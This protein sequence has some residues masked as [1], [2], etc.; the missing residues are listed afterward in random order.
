MSFTAF[1]TSANTNHGEF[2]WIPWYH[3]APSTHR[4]KGDAND[5]FMC[6]L[7]EKMCSNATSWNASNKLDCQ[8]IHIYIHIIRIYIYIRIYKLIYTYIHSPVWASLKKT[9]L[10][11]KAFQ[12]ALESRK[13]YPKKKH[14]QR[15]SLPSQLSSPYSFKNDWIFDRNSK[16]NHH[17]TE[18][19]TCFSWMFFELSTFQW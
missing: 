16:N 18:N 7:E 9:Q 6:M 11:N 5:P 10:S 8:Y 2:M 13:F 12:G 14:K 4:G 3:G 1:D 17:P 15:S 19:K